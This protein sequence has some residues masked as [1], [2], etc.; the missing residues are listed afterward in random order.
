M[1]TLPLVFMNPLLR[2]IPTYSPSALEHGAETQT[3]QKTILWVMWKSQ[4]V[5]SLNIMQQQTDNHITYV[6]QVLCIVSR[7]AVKPAEYYIFGNISLVKNIN[8]LCP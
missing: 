1:I 3:F 2:F 6:H 8:A 7:K 4:K 5:M